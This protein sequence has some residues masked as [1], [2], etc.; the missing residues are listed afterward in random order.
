MV[1]LINVE[2]LLAT[3]IINKLNEKFCKLQSGAIGMV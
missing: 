1:P 2:E 3:I